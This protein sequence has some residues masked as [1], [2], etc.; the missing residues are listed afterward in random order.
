MKIQNNLLDFSENFENTHFRNIYIFEKMYV[1]SKL[2]YA[3]NPLLCEA[4]SSLIFILWE[5]FK[6]GIHRS[7]AFPENFLNF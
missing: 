2:T 3:S 5:L 1:S 4:A 7:A 6:F